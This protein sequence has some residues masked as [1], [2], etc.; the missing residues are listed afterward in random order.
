MEQSQHLG[1]SG[2]CSSKETFGRFMGLLWGYP[3]KEGEGSAGG[4][5][6]TDY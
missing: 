1:D 4:L 6:E 5:V 2:P 3:C